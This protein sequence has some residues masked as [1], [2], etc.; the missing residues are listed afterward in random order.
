MTVPADHRLSRLCAVP[1]AALTGALIALAL[2]G[3]AS[4]TS[5]IAPEMQLQ[6]LDPGTQVFVGTVTAREL[7]AVRLRVD[8]WFAGPDPREMV[9]IPLLAPGDP[10]VVGTWDP[11]PGQVWFI[12]GDRIGPETIDSSVCR[13]V[14]ADPAIVSAATNHF[15]APR[16]P[17]F[18]DSTAPETTGSG[19]VPLAIGAGVLIL[20][21]L[22]GLGAVLALQRRVG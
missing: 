14:P 6:N 2:A 9:A 8:Q 4:A 5:C 15:G 7:G 13:Q 1:M 3:P 11:T 22:G 16:M 18:S 21:L 17:P 10:I 19:G 20:G 12:I